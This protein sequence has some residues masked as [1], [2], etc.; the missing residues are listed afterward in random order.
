MRVL[1]LARDHT[2]AGH[3][4][5]FKVASQLGLSNLTGRRRSKYAQNHC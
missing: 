4:R 2:D 5:K 1:P 3:L